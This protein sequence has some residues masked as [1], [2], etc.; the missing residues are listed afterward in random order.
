MVD[1]R[2]A[3]DIMARDDGATATLAKV[4]R[5][6][7]KTGNAA[8]RNSKI[9]EKAAA[10][11]AAL[12]K[13]HAAES[14]A[15]DKVQVAES[16]LSN[17]RETAKGKTAA[18]QAAE[19]H[20]LQ[21]RN[22][23][24]TSTSQI[25]AAEAR[26]EKAR[27]A[28]RTSTTNVIAGEKG[29][30][31][32]RRDAAI[33]GDVAQKAAKDLTKVL[34][35]EGKKAGNGLLRG[36]ENSA[37]KI[38]GSLKKWVTGNPFKDAG[39]A[40]GTV[41]GSGFLGALKTPILGPAIVAVLLSAVAVAAPAVGAVLAGGIV[42]GFGAGLVALGA[43]FAAKSVA[44]KNAWNRSLWD[45][46]AD[47]KVISKPF[48]RT[49]VDM[50]AFARRTFLALA[51]ALSDAFEG[52]GPALSRFGDD[53]G[54]AFE[55]LGPSIR[56]LSV[57]FEAVLK[58][59]GPA[60]Q[61]AL[62]SFAHGLQTIAASVS[63]NPDGLSDLVRGTGKLFDTISGGLAM[64]N[65]LN[66]AFKAL[67]G[68]TSAVTR[69]MDTLTFFVKAALGP[70][71]EL[72]LALRGVNALSH[73][74]EIKPEGF[75][76]AQQ[77]AAQTVTSLQAVR[78]KAGG[79]GA[80]LNGLAAA[81]GKSAHETHA[82]NVAAYLLATAYDRQWAATQKA[83]DAL[84]RM[85]GLLLTLSGSEIAF[86]QAIDDATASIKENGKTHDISTEKGRANK[87]AL[88][89]VAAS[90][91]AQTIAM[92]NAGDGNVSAARHAE[93]A[94]AN[95][96]KLATQMGYTVPQ[97]KA[98]ANS[99]IAIPNV[100]RTAKLN[101]NIADLQGKL[102]KA[103]QYLNDHDLTKERRAKLNADITAWQ[104]KIAT[105]KKQLND[106]NLTKERKAKLN[107]EIAALQAKV[108]TA[109]GLLNNKELTKERKAKLLANIANLQAGIKAA[110]DALAGVP[111]SKT[112]TITTRYSIVGTKAAIA[113]ST[114]GG[115]KIDGRASGGP[116]TA[117]Q[118]YVVGENGPEIVV[119]NTNSTV[120]PNNAIKTGSN[121]VA[122]LA[123]GAMGSASSAYSAVAQVAAGMI[124]K[125]Q[126]VLGISSPSKAFAKLGLYVTQGFAIGLR[127]SAKQV[128][129]VM[130]SLMS[131][132]LDIAF[133]AAD[134]KKAAQKNIAAYTAAISAAR[135][136]IR[137][138]TPGMSKAEADKVRRNNAA[139]AQSIKALQAKLA[140][141]KIDLANVNAIASRLG[142]TKK[143]NAVI[144]MI[145]RENVAMQ[146]L[147][148]A[149]AV[150]A[151]QLKAAQDKLAAAIQVRD[152]FR[153]AITD[154]AMAFNAIT[155][156]QAPEGQKLTASNIIAQMT[157]TLRR[158]QQFAANLARLKKSGLNATT[159]KQI[160]EAG[161]DQGG[162]IADA[163]LS[164]GGNTFNS[165]NRLQSNINSAAAGLGS[166][167][168]AN[169][170][171]AGV[172]AAQG[173]VNGLLAKTKALDAASKKLAA[174]IV[175]Q[176]KKTLGI[177]SPS[178]VLE[179]H[180]S[181]AG[182]G[183]ELGIKGEYG[184]VQ[185]AAAGLGA[186]AA[187]GPQARRTGVPASGGGRGGDIYITINGALD[188]NAVALQIQQLLKRY[189]RTGG[190]V[191]A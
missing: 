95:F 146:K 142:T 97:A 127:G 44:V 167:A 162:A 105:A 120:I 17:A 51:P 54:R 182:R 78:D 29:L 53:L 138:V 72:E 133:N 163:L 110:K 145:Q 151:V 137:P 49:L 19:A 22:D 129:S 12:T 77:A 28:A 62:S 16:K 59:L 41:F 1:S 70:F 8:Q 176:I 169:L 84:T 121:V 64:L 161:V 23:S 147:A 155:N 185:K 10:A 35:T 83:N 154:S 186:A 132:V 181:M 24:G 118:P 73:S 26:L 168:A 21:A 9:S 99:L 93:G 126:D 94:R 40:G 119:P 180:G 174:A 112:V 74:M 109:K 52:L 128:Q 113:A 75:A 104:A 36:F 31:K 184:R 140:S 61:S 47:M 115:G 190:V 60:M 71:A 122:G 98:M 14:N 68:G 65:N 56:P 100:S 170:Y 82:A 144:G 85:S 80:G 102:T 32:A 183:F 175:A 101:A 25:A 81:A 136:K 134:T 124:A 46:A 114:R 108:T 2:L 67:P 27:S 6:L 96:I 42:A 76:A 159:Y 166:T 125:A 156:I 38:P 33:A 123:Q 164:G 107:A 141:A 188:P 7:D 48:E 50:A 135:K 55:K 160:A 11:S 34:D 69:A 116:M 153:K 15:L 179:W 18:V 20:L 189:G 39:Q 143:R 4:E 150:V 57:A 79:A 158:T 191:A 165:I 157:E 58:S 172:D 152:E 5:A 117:G 43:V 45:M 90:A 149:R 111:S 66:T 13:A 88:D 131:K 106:P 187:P 92:R 173:L 3:F 139:A 30:A 130:A 89:Q 171:Q 103:K 87:T 37:K 178:K 91:N 177:R 148:N 63:K 86:Q